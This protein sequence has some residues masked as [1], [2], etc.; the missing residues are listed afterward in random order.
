MA[1]EIVG[2]IN[3]IFI[4][5]NLIVPSASKA[6]VQDVVTALHGLARSLSDDERA[7]AQM[8]A[9]NSKASNFRLGRQFANDA[10]DSGAVPIDIATVARHCGDLLAFFDNC[11]IVGQDYAL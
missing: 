7:G 1:A 10:S 2:L 11:H 3:P 6:A 9:Q 5:Q 8:L 4:E